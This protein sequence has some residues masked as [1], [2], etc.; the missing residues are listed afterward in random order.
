MSEEKKLSDKELLKTV[1][2]L[3]KSSIT[4]QMKILHITN[5]LSYRKQLT[6]EYADFAISY[7]GLFNTIIENPT[8]FDIERLLYMLDMK[9]KIQN[10][11]ITFETASNK[12][13]QEYYNEYIKPLIDE[14]DETNRDN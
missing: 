2:N 11:N 6:D 5:E 9:K 8:K 10:N 1:N 4:D 14:T 13:G 12:I 3:I 7:P